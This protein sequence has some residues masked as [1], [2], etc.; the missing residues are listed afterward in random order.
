MLFRD[1]LSQVLSQMLEEEG[2][3]GR[4][5]HMGRQGM[6]MVIFGAEELRVKEGHDVISNMSK[7]TLKFSSL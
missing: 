7:K 1:L 5:V 3:N 2:W 6:Y 4:A